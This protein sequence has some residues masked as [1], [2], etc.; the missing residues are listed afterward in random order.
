MQRGA[1]L[2]YARVEEEEEEEEEE[3]EEEEEEEEGAN[4]YR[5]T[6][7]IQPS[8]FGLRVGQQ[9]VEQ[10]QLLGEGPGRN[11]R[12]RVRGCRLPR[13]AGVGHVLYN[14]AGNTAGPWNWQIL[15]ATVRGCRLPQ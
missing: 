6:T 9:A 12:S 4:V 15:P 13:G 1:E 3:K 8:L 14:V 10:R 2:C 11:C 5:R 7:S